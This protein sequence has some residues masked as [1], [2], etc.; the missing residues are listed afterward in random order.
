[1]KIEIYDIEK[2][3]TCSEEN[4]LLYII[5]I[6]ELHENTIVNPKLKALIIKCSK[7]NFVEVF[8]PDEKKWGEVHLNY[9]FN[10]NTPIM[11]FDNEDEAI[12][13]K[14]KLLYKCEQE[15]LTYLRNI[16]TNLRET[17]TTENYYKLLKENPEITI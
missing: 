3:I 7:A 6:P 15:M 11:C 2:Y 16:E 9:I 8:N 10:K 17:L 1:M 12:K 14:L 4:K 13:Y 5:K